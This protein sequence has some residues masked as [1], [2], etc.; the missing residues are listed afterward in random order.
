MK[1]PLH[2]K[3]PERLRMRAREERK[4]EANERRTKENVIENQN[5]N[6]ENV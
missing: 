1:K 4:S 2:R 3:G 5:D 6:V